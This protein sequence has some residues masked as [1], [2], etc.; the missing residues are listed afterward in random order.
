MRIWHVY[1]SPRLGPVNGVVQLMH[2]LADAQRDLGHEV[3]VLHGTEDDPRLRPARGSA[4]RLRSTALDRATTSPPDIVHLHELFR[5]PHL[6]LHRILRDVPYVV[7]TH[8]A[9]SPQ[10]LDRYK[11]RKAAYSR[12]IERRV[13]GSARAL[14]ASTP[15]EAEE[16]RR[17]HP[18]PPAIRVLANVADPAL[19]RA[20]P[21]SPPGLGAAVTTL[22]RFDVRHKGLD[23]LASLAR[24]MPGE[25]FSVHG[26]RC[27]NEPELL[28]RLLRDLPANLHLCEPVR[29]EAKAQALHDAAAFILLSRWE[30]LSVA[31][32][33]ALAA[34]VPC[35]VSAEVAATLGPEP[36]VLVL[37]TDPRSRGSTLGALLADDRARRALGER[38]RRWALTHASPE[39]VGA[40]SLEI[41][42]EARAGRPTEDAVAHERAG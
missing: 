7:S 39:A 37:R 42:E 2:H 24:T 32:L 10:N 15:V 21:W 28:D 23:R 25:T 4:R 9:T 20:A 13:V 1:A 38:G 30:G 33:E 12:L 17:W 18:D 3:L 34:G 41:Y 35:V 22:G 31:L 19:L 26:S 11:V 14:I 16:L 36:P 5:P 29:G 27:G 6:T 40:R 8:G